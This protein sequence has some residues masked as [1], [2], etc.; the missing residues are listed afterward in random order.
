MLAK[1]EKYQLILISFRVKRIKEII[2]SLLLISF[3]FLVIVFGTYG[4]FKNN[5]D[6]TGTIYLIYAF[7]VS[8]L[9]FFFIFIY[10]LFNKKRLCITFIKNLDF[11]LLFFIC[12]LLLVSTLQLPIYMLTAIL[13][14]IS[15]VLIFVT[16][17]NFPVFRISVLKSFILLN[18]IIYVSSILALVGGLVSFFGDSFSIGPIEFYYEKAYWRMNSWYVSSTGLGIFFIYGIYSSIYF[19]K[20]T[21]FWFLKFWFLV[22]ILA[23]IFGMSLAGGRTAFVSIILSFILTYIYVT[24]LRPIFLIKIFISSILLIIVFVYIF[25]LYSEEIYILR[26]F[27]DEDALSLGGRSDLFSKFFDSLTT[28]NPYQ[29]IFGVGINGTRELLKWDVSPHSGFLRIIIENG[30]IAFLSLLMLIIIT[31]ISLKNQVR[32]SNVYRLEFIIICLYLTSFFIS[33][34]MVIQLFGISIEYILFLVV[35]SFFSVFKRIDIDNN[36]I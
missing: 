15:T 11:Q 20:K 18:K 6:S 23:L 4:T 12:L 34:I 33:E 28:L 22:S 2:T 5:S 24:P 27:A 10:Y 25:N 9:F 26:R 17:F 35:F 32:Y 31:S 1:I 3:W 16:I 8:V 36:F 21:R 14:L 19:I 29:F 30:P 13:T 7:P